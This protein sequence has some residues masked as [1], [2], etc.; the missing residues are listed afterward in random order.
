MKIDY[1]QLAFILDIK[2]VEALEKIIY[3]DC[4]IKGTITP[5][6]C[7]TVKEYLFDKQKKKSVRNHWPESLEVSLLAEHLNL[8]TLQQSIDDIKN[9]YLVRP[10]TKR[11]ILCDFPEKE[12]KTKLK[13]KVRI[14]AVLQTMLKPEDVD[15]IQTEWNKRYGITFS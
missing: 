8:P 9:N 6:S 5:R 3:V 11:W 14:P 13:E 1:K 4:K 12:L 15:T 10:G 7:D 2:P